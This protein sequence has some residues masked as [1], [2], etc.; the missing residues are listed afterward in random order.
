[1][2]KTFGMTRIWIVA[3]L[4]VVGFVIL[5]FTTNIMEVELLMYLCV[6]G[7]SYVLG[8]ADGVGGK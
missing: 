8:F 2:E 5:L 1:M 6:F 4:C 3:I 7:M